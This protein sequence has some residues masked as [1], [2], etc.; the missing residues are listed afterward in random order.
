MFRLGFLARALIRL[1][2][3]K[4]FRISVTIILTVLATAMLHSES[5][6]LGD[7]GMQEN[8]AHAIFNVTHYGASG[9]DQSSLGSVARA[10]TTLKLDTPLDFK[11]GEGIKI[12]HA[13]TPCALQNALCQIGP[14]LVVTRQG[15]AGSTTYSYQLAVIDEGGGVGPAGPAATITNGPSL[16]S[17]HSY[18]VIRWEAIPA[19]CGYALYR[20]NQLLLVLSGLTPEGYY[21]HPKGPAFTSSFKDMGL[22]A[23]KKHYPDIPLTPPKAALADALI[24]TVTSGGGS[25]LELREKASSSVQQSVV[26][27]DDSEAIQS[28]LDAAVPGATVYFPTGSYLFSRQG[29]LIRGSSLKLTGSGNQLSILKDNLIGNSFPPFRGTEPCGFLSPVDFSN[30]EISNLALY[31]LAPFGSS[32]TR[33]KKA[34]C[35]SGSFDRLY[36]HDVVARNI[37]GEAIYAEDLKRGQV[38]FSSNTIEDCSKNGLNT[39][40]LALTNVSV[41]DNVVHKVNGAAILVV[42]QNAL[43][44][45]NK[46]TGGAPSGADVVNVAVGKLFTIA[47]NEIS[48]LDT[49]L[50]ATS[51]IHIGFYGS[52]LNGSGV[53][54][55]NLITDNQTLNETSGG[56]IFVDDVA[57]PVLIENNIMERNRG[58]CLPGNPAIS[59]ANKVDEIL[60]VGNTMR[61]SEPY[62]DVGIR[63]EKSVPTNNRIVIRNNKIETRQPTVFK[64]TPQGVSDGDFSELL[65]M[66]KSWKK[67]DGK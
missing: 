49:S 29:F 21:Q 17:A 32:M 18:N 59:I 42:S 19:A 26:S 34:I 38:I 60:V 30:I 41:T 56:A 64:V 45:R 10:E 22:V 44:A 36:V 40:S 8:V 1:C 14:R 58:C 63:I 39:N 48:G 24:T 3:R 66:A 35:A 9:S 11:Q 23:E 12:E 54:I 16:L 67:A 6:L 47:A 61:G 51:L 37:S 27:H 5:V 53:V 2:C 13:G 4:A 62:Q 57:Q 55:G 31:G 65:E 46:I 43:V 7:F 25:I 15:S 20:N 52:G 50:A 33:R 28:A